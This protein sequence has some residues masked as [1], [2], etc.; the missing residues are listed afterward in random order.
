[1]TSLY[2]ETVSTIPHFC[3]DFPPPKEAPNYMHYTKM[4][5]YTRSYADRFGITGRVRLRHEVLQV[6]KAEEYDSTGRWD[7]VVKDLNGD[8]ESRQTFD[9]VLVASG[10]YK[11]PHV[12]TF[13]G[14]KKFKGKILH[15][16]NLK[17]PGKFKERRVAVVG[18]GNSGVDAAVDACH[19]A[20]EV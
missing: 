3:S 4:L 13:K 18:I 10:H 6:T 11:F 7:A 19:V 12:P 16:H 20:A 8:V 9:A 15:R 1:L 17:V 5:A 2:S 14:Q